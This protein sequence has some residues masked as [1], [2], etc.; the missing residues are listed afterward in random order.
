MIEGEARLPG[1][2]LLILALAMHGSIKSFWKRLRASG[3]KVEAVA[4]DMSLAYIEAV[5]T[6]LPKA[7]LVFDRF[8]LIKL[9]NE[10]LSALRRALYHQLK[11]SMQKDVLCSK[12]FVGCC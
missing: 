10:K 2:T 9:Y 5:T 6:H 4:T 7:T 11:D 8:H 3:A 1:G 12:A